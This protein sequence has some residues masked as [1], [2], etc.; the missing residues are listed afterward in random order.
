MIH[1]L[2][3]L[4]EA[5][6]GRALE[7]H[8]DP[9]AW[10]LGGVP[11]EA[12]VAPST[13]E[14]VGVVVA[15]A[16]RERF[17]VVPM[18]GMTRPGPEAPVGPYVV[19]STRR[20][21]EVED[22]EPA[23]LT[24]TA[25][26]GL[27]LE[28]LD[29]VLAEKGQWLPADPPLAPRRTLGGMV[30]TGTVGP[31]GT[32]YGAPRDHV[33]GL[34]VVTGDGRVL[35]LG[36]RV[37]KNVAGFDLVKLMVGSHGTLGVVVSASLRLFPKPAT[38]GVWVLRGDAPGALMTVARRVATAAVMPASAVLTVASA[39]EG[40]AAAL[41]VR[42]QGAAPAV[43]ADAATLLGPDLGAAV[44]H[45][46]GGAREMA[47]LMRDHGS[48]Y[49]VVLR[50]FAL[51]SLLPEVLDAVHGALPGAALNADV[52]AGRVRAGIPVEGA[53]PAAVALLRDRL[54]A[55]GGTLVVE[56]APADL[57]ERV[58]VRGSAGRA[59]ALSAALRARF[60]PSGV[61]SPG[62]YLP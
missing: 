3:A 46:E 30:A 59:G 42:I 43:E 47:A 40:G 52:L 19:L 6:P 44:V 15:V 37:M 9:H 5:L 17:G 38:E 32:A 50:A 18:G 1:A 20:L 16:A 14:E 33:L 62:R 7:G 53:D 57:V 21:D 13:L 55:L 22:Y 51:P 45:E 26:A 24:V 25:Q 60:D 39:A 4:T 10:A 58:P 35:R 48:E 11:P 36:G 2:R 12:V 27:T 49:P 28:A 34:T 8:A 56:R 23:D 29:R 41:A 31:L 61:L 54:E